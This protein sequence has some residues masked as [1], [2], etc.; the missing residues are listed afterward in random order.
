MFRTSSILFRVNL[1][2]IFAVLSFL[3][4]SLFYVKMQLDQESVNQYN[5]IVSTIG[6]MRQFNV[7]MK[8]IRGYLEE[9]GFHEIEPS[10][11]LRRKIL[12]SDSEPSLGDFNV[13][14]FQNGNDIFIALRTDQYFVVYMDHIDFVWTQ[15]HTVIVLGSVVLVLVYGALINHLMP[16]QNVKNELMD[17]T[18][19]GN[20]KKLV[21]AQSNKDEIGDLVREFNY[22]V[23][24]LRSLEESR[25]LFLR[26]IMHEL[27]TPLTKGRIVAEGIIDIKQKSLICNVFERL[28]SLID[29]FAKIEELASKNYRIH[30]KEILLR[31]ILSEVKAMLLTDKSTEERII[32]HH[33]NDLIKADFDLFA[34]VLK[35]L[36]DNGLKYS[37]DSKVIVSATKRD[38]IIKSKSAPLALDINDYFK[39]YFKDIKNPLSK[40][41]GLGMYIIKNALDTQNLEL[42]YRYEDGYNL[43]IIKECIVESFCGLPKYYNQTRNRLDVVGD[44]V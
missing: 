25:L 28:N 13:H 18:I 14:I 9:Q 30:K 21:C 11:E 2:F 34:L 3:S 19:E 40:G 42:D 12:E 1:L 24:R 8:E 35:N 16:L 29:E 17:M 37:I 33:N 41:F 32:T 38:L 44:D 43:F 20:L 15:Y 10:Q 22:V 7:S 6:K 27:K 31:D 23:D 26:S 5:A 4:A 36:I 39:P